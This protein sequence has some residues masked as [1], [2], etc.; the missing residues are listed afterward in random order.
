MD[1]HEEAISI[2]GTPSNMLGI[3]S[4]PA[5]GAHQSHIAV[6]VVVGGDQYRV[7]SHRQFVR[8]A[9]HLASAGH[10]VLR[11]D[12]PGMGDSPGE[13]VAFEAAS[14]HIAAA[15][16]AVLSHCPD[17]T[18]VV[19]WGLCDGASAILLYAHNTQDQRISGLVLLN[20]WVRSETSLARAQ[21]KH[22]YLWRLAERAFWHKLISGK[23]GWQAL[24]DLGNNVLALRR[25][26]PGP[27]SFQE[28]MADGWRAFSGH[29]LLLLSE[30][31]LVAKEFM[32]HAQT[33]ARWAGL[34]E[35]PN[36]SHSLVE[37]A[38]H[39]FSSSTASRQTESF[40]LQWLSRM[41]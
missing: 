1:I 16:N 38:D 29:T 21:V 23:V 22:Y 5:L 36:V 26:K 14:P 11:F 19:L 6:V 31:D 40:V 30:R 12:F 39:T 37:G 33:D 4:K 25:P 20:P 18:Q 41:K 35:R 10:P 15:V 24:K 2:A 17:V 28:A 7:G 9:R 27:A 8:M 32:E 3:I 13:T 34:L